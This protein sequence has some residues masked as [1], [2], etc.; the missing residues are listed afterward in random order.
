MRSILMNI[1]LGVTLGTAMLTPALA[2]QDFSKVEITTTKLSDTLYMLMGA[3]GNIGVSAGA[4]GVYLIDDQYAPLSE[5]IM[6]AVKAISDKPVKYVVNTHWHGD[7]TGG[8]ENFGK[9]GAT[10]IA[11]EAVRARMAKGGELAAFKMAVPPA[12]AGALPVITFDDMIAL[13]QNGET[14]RVI[15]VDPAHTDGDAIIHWPSANVIHTGDTFVNGVF[16]FVDTSSG[17]KLDGIIKSAD[18]VLA[19]ADDKTKI[20]PGHGPL[21]TRADLVRFR[22]MVVT[23]RERVTAAKAAGKTAEEWAAS[24]P[25]ADLDADW[26]KGF[27]PVDKFTQIVFD[28]I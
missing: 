20:I 23:V 12:A 19:L 6:A 21:A 25:L 15:H 5:K 3:G 9:A 10:I 11:H 18:T 27:L 16:P 26:G 8:N 2:Q 4:D 7:H 22:A 17:G 13:H 28:A 24:K 1:A 14:A